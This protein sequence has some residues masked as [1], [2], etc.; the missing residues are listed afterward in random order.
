M[1]IIK[2]YKNYRKKIKLETL[3]ELFKWFNDLTVKN[4]VQGYKAMKVWSIANNTLFEERTLKGLTI[5]K[6][7][8]TL[9]TNHLNRIN[10]INKSLLM[11]Q[12][13]ML[14]TIA[15][16]KKHNGIYWFRPLQYPDNAKYWKMG[17]SLIRNSD[18]FLIRHIQKVDGNTG[19]TMTSR[20]LQFLLNDVVLKLNTGS[21]DLGLRRKWIQ[22]PAPKPRSLTIPSVSARIISSMW[23]EIL[24]QY[25]RFEQHE[26]THAYQAYKGCN[27]A[28][29]WILSNYRSIWNPYYTTDYAQEVRGGSSPQG[30]G[31]SP[32]G[33]I[34][35]GF[36]GQR[37]REFEGNLSNYKYIY[38]FDLENFF[39]SV[40]HK[41]LKS[42]MKD[43]GIPTYIINY[44]V[45]PLS[46][47]PVAAFDLNVPDYQSGQPDFIHKNY[48]Q[49]FNHKGES[50]F[51]LG[52]ASNIGVPMGLGYS[53]LLACLV[54]NT[55][56]KKWKNDKNNFI[57]YGD[58]GMIM[59]NEGKELERFKKLLK[60]HEVK[61]NESK[62]KWLIYEYKIQHNL[63]FLGLNLNLR[64]GMLRADTR[65]GKNLILQRYTGNLKDERQI[66]IMRL[67]TTYCAFGIKSVL[68]AINAHSSFMNKFNI[69]GEAVLAYAKIVGKKWIDK[70]E[71][72]KDLSRYQI[73][74][75]SNEEKLGPV[76]KISK[77]NPG[78]RYG[79]ALQSVMNK[80]QR[81]NTWL[82]KNNMNNKRLYSTI[83]FHKYYLPKELKTTL[84]EPPVQLRL[85]PNW[86]A[87]RR[88]AL[89]AGWAGWESRN[90]QVEQALC[91]FF[92]NWYFKQVLNIRTLMA[93][94]LFNQ[95]QSYLYNNSFENLEYES[96]PL[97][98]E[99]NSALFRAMKGIEIKESM[100]KFKKLI[101]I[102]KFEISGFSDTREAIVSTQ[103]VS[104]YNN[105]L[106]MLE[107]KNIRRKLW[108]TRIP[109][110]VLLHRW[111]RLSK[112]CA[113]RISLETPMLTGV[114]KF[115]EIIDQETVQRIYEV[116]LGHK[117]FMKFKHYLIEN[118]IQF[119]IINL[120]RNEFGLYTMELLKK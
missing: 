33:L 91:L 38:E 45:D 59:Y 70:N 3:V 50:N 73:W 68:L 102:K 117:N 2:V 62:S 86:L 67:W 88:A 49:L 8:I 85:I 66:L 107:L 64:T 113:V 24:E 25:L 22:A 15:D 23:T 1:K 55:L 56:L 118:K 60:E 6:Y 13:M 54:L 120:S 101:T 114:G 12:I 48:E 65:K 110:D 32:P 43:V 58:D 78:G 4:P 100:D 72:K 87:R 11:Y 105:R 16:V 31:Q 90:F 46:I 81:I 75:R 112:Q 37:K 116:Q 95:A 89:S 57:T 97:Q 17:H 30:Q 29:K 36:E 20:K 5:E 19:N 84:K 51:K 26:N 119:Q 40:S 63:K 71:L 98:L 103:N 7:K 76:V 111:N 61:L 79:T 82:W 77:K 35:S 106:I 92:E 39:P 28:W 9:K 69:N 104:S 44:M 93:S 34:W 21:W 108:K 109:M 27:T 53:P 96:P 99:K 10:S 41:V 52:K 18:G 47:K 80:I 94:N 42:C 74:R 14:R 83:K 115:I